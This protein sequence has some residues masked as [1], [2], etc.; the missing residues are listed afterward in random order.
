MRIDKH[1]CPG[2]RD[3]LHSNLYSPRGLVSRDS[4]PENWCRLIGGR[5]G[6]VAAVLAF[7][8]C[9]I[10]GITKYG[11]LLGIGL[12][13]LPAATVAWLTA[14]LVAMPATVLFRYMII[15]SRYFSTRMHAIKLHR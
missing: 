15:G 9:Y 5:L 2:S 8:A 13:W 12:G 14:H 4:D 6:A 11:P 3:S 10:F 1:Q 7:I